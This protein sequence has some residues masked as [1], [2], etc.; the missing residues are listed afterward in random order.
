MTPAHKFAALE[1]ARQLYMV[2]DVGGDPITNPAELA[3]K[4]GL[5][6]AMIVRNIG[7]WSTELVAIAQTC[8]AKF[9]NVT[10]PT[11]AD[12]NCEDIVFLRQQ[13]DKIRKK[14]E[15]IEDPNDHNY[16]QLLVLYNNITE[17][18]RKLS[19]VNAALE[20]SAKATTLAAEAAIK[21]TIKPPGGNP[22]ALPPSS[23]FDMGVDV[24]EAEVVEEQSPPKPKPKPKPKLLT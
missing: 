16:H 18:W 24:L 23:I 3:A 15:G 19:G 13:A 14:L 5:S 1:R 7:L 12:A 20:I 17:K 11:I 2:G 4:T 6:Q 21:G 8:N 22:S 9:G 10:D